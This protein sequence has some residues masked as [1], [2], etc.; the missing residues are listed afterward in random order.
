MPYSII[1]ASGS[2][3]RRELMDRIGSRY[4][5]IP[6]QKEED[7]SGHD[8]E[9]MVEMLSAMKAGDIAEKLIG[10][11]LTPYDIRS[12]EPAESKQKQILDLQAPESASV[13]IGCDTVV[14]F[15]N[16]ILGKPKDKED[17]F[18][19]IKSFAGRTHHVHTGVCI[20]VVE[21][22]Q[23]VRKLNYSI[24]TAVKV[25]DMTD[26]EILAYIA[27]GEPMDKA[28]AYA[29]QGLFCPYV[30]SIE[31]DYYNIVGFPI[32]SIYR[33]FKELNIDIRTGM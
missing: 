10:S 30:D 1:L 27:T 8:P 26:E 31:G 16:K 32:A 6:S 25:V 20:L 18:T 21:N 7:M 2:P 23:I 17:A 5:C 33:S 24:S 14:A 9:I 12:D 11:S 4:I 3:R 28:G 29:I 19:M 13:I 22:R 15:E